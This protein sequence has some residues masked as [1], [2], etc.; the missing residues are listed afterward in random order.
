M[1]DSNKPIERILQ[2]A[3]FKKVIPYLKGDVMDFGGNKGELRKFVKG[4]YLVVNYDHSVMKGK[5]FDTIVALAII[6][7]IVFN[8]VF[9]IFRK[10]KQEHL[11]ENGVIFLTTPTKISRPV[12]DL[13]RLTGI[14]RGDSDEHK[15]YWN[16]REIYDLA[17]KSGFIVEKYQ[18]FQLGLNQMAI[19]KNGG[20]L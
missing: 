14:G 6:E 5:T 8:E 11:K 3:R 19:F 12:L 2:N 4:N 7:H 1:L 20:T 18:K 9:D 10:F 13:M 15:H 17:K 16:K